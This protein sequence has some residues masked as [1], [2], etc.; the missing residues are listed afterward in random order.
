MDQGRSTSG[1]DFSV[2]G[3]IEGSISSFDQRAREG[4]DPC[5]VDQVLDQVLQLKRIERERDGGC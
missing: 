5:G 2:V 4:G 1:R 3:R